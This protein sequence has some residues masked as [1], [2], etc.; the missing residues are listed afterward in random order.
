[1]TGALNKTIVHPYLNDKMFVLY[2]YWLKSIETRPNI[3]ESEWLKY[4]FSEQSAFVERVLQKKFL[5]YYQLTF[6]GDK[7][8][9][10]TTYSYDKIYDA[11][12]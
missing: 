9:I 7:L 3:L 4:C 2:L 1:M 8:K 6:T 10:E 11:I 12:K 5:K